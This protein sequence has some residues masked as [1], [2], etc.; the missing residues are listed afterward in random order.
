MTPEDALSVSRASQLANSICTAV[1][2]HILG[3]PTEIRL[4]VAC[5][6]ADGHLLIE[7]VPGVGKT[8]LARA[9]AEACGLAWHR[10]QFTSD[11]LPTDLLGVSVWESHSAQFVFRPGPLFAELVLADEINRAPPKT[12]SALLEAMEE[13]RV[14]VEGE[15]RPLPSPFFVIATQNPT[16]HAG[17]FPLPESQ[18]DRFLMRLSLGYPPEEAEVAL[19]SGSP[20]A[21]RLSLAPVVD[22]AI[23]L[24]LQASC[25]NIH[26]SEAIARY[27]R[28]LL[29]ASRLNAEFSLGLSPRAGLALL[30]AARA[31]ALL[32]GRDFVAP[33]DVQ[34]AW[35]PVAGHRITGRDGLP[36]PEA[37][38]AALLAATPI[39]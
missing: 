27:I 35:L 6:L 30:S 5:L 28:R 8:T 31:L 21:R 36:A 1:G 33:E 15:T 16:W 26:A 39:E 23:L 12:Q 17:T 38:V 20:G 3:K 7:D 14:S 37:A 9:L 34:Q 13:G 24:A 4:A 18:L 25:A 11:M 10:L 29:E 32:E 2:L 19:L 22:R